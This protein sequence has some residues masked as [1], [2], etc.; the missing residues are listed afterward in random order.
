[1]RM[2]KINIFWRL[3]LFLGL[4]SFCFNS[5]AQTATISGNVKDAST[6]DPLIG[7]NIVVRGKVIGTTT[8]LNGD[9]KLQTNSVP[10]PFTLVFSSVGYDPK[11][12]EVNQENQTIEITLDEKAILADE[13]V[14]SASR[15][16]EN[17]LESPVT[18]E[19]MDILAIQ[20]APSDDYFKAIGNLKGVDVGTSSINFQVYNARGYNS[21]SNTRFVQLID[22]MDS[23]APALNFPVSNLN[24]PSQLDIESIE[25]L[26]G[27]ASALYGP[28]AFNGILLMNSKNPFEYQGLSAYTKVGL[29]HIGAETSE[30]EPDGAQ[31]L[32]EVSL[33]YAKAFNNK[34][35]FKVNFSYSGAEDWYGTDDTDLK[36]ERQGALLNN[37][38]ADK[39]HY[40][41]D[42]ASISLPLVGFQLPGNHP[43]AQYYSLIPN[44]VVSRTPYP[45]P[46]LVDYD[47]KNI[48]F[49]AALHYR[50]ND[51]LELSY[52]GSYGG[53][54]T[55]Y[56]GAQRY[57][58][59]NFGI[60]QHKVE[61]KGSN[62]FVRG[63]TT[64]EDSGDSY[65]V[66]GVAA[67]INSS[68]KS[69]GDWFGE[70]T[71]A[72]LGALAQRYPNPADAANATAEE[73]TAFHDAARA[74]ADQGRL[75]PGTSEFDQARERIKDILI[76][77]GGKFN[78]QTRFYHVEGQYNFSD[79][80]DFMDL[81]VGA[82]YRLFDLRSNGTIFADTTG[83]D[84]TIQEYGLYAQA[85][86][87]LLDDKLKL[88]GSLRYDKNE[89]FDGQI[90]PRI[91]AVLKV[92]DQH[93]FRLSYQTGFRLP[94]T[95]EQHI[96]LDVG[97]AR[98]LG[99]L[100]QY[101]EANNIYQYAYTRNSVENYVQQVTNQGTL[102]AAL[103]PQ[104][105]ALL[106]PVQDGGYAPVKPEQVKSI[107]VGYK[108]L[109]GKNLMVDAVYYY[110]L[111]SDFTVQVAI[112]KAAGDISVNPINAQS[113]L[114]AT[115]ANTYQVYTNL[116]ED[117]AAHGAAI[118]IDY[119][120]NKGYTAGLNYN[121]NKQIDELGD[122]FVNGFNTPEHKLNLSVSNRKVTDRLGFSVSYRWQS[123]F[124][125]EF[126]FAE[127][128]VPS[129]STV[130]AQVSYRLK[131]L[132]S[133]VK[134]GGSNL[135]NNRYV[136]NI[137]G[138]TIGA[139]Y[140]LSLTFDQFMN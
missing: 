68:W 15:V 95:Q 94:S 42:I 3:L 129:Y 132:K 28:N 117:L 120:F 60:Q 54:T 131:E 1:M 24:G 127:G 83:N 139:I 32:Y 88:T 19:K 6:N 43:L 7:V 123:D 98:L 102:A 100:P 14:V 136:Q 8:D 106:N 47:A 115:S 105:L 89:N 33:R 9:F 79:M 66:D 35:A 116:T 103:S 58:L 114:V 93:N 38:G 5:I 97:T 133:V 76:P 25:F 130:D 56:L 21:T 12:V 67:G 69:N 2:N 70:Y 22:G 55:V 108:S 20:N 36:P 101:A 126:S 96:S 29:N 59:S 13:V 121:W 71:L 62:F 11:E 86:K 80:I 111:Y 51:D 50:I 48:K 44:Q 90:N 46:P 91:S 77:N 57:S 134:L 34:F 113:L 30:G 137:G 110:N 122:E 128:D 81:Q 41:G 84:I 92:A 104:N 27:A 82:S 63:Y 118:G 73:R 26:P 99:G 16:E 39:V 138:P 109:I 65:I 74:F 107:E 72:Y 37:P 49:N 119:L 31:P 85:T 45:E 17:I 124:R 53:G 61:L 64:I 18:V 112:V 23:Q 4:T 87:R 140:Y 78:D 135:L 52:L 10:L 125:W 40:Y 75:L